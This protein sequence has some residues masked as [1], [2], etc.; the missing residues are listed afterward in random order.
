MKRTFTALALA[1]AISSVVHSA[2]DHSVVHSANDHSVAHLFN[3]YYP[4]EHSSAKDSSAKESCF[5]SGQ[6][7]ISYAA[8]SQ[9]PLRAGFFET[10][11]R[12]GFWHIDRGIDML[13]VTAGDKL[14]GVEIKFPANFKVKS[15]ENDSV[16]EISYNVTAAHHMP[17]FPSF[18]DF[19]KED[20]MSGKAMLCDSSYFVMFLTDQHLFATSGNSEPLYLPI[21]SGLVLQGWHEISSD[22]LP[23]VNLKILSATE[24]QQYEYEFL[25]NRLF[26]TLNPTYLDPGSIKEI[27]ETSAAYPIHE[28]ELCPPLDESEICAFN[29]T[30]INTRNDSDKKT[31][32]DEVQEALLSMA[33]GLNNYARQQVELSEQENQVIVDAV[34]NG[35]EGVGYILK[36]F[37]KA[38]TESIEGYRRLGAEILI[39]ALKDG[40]E[41]VGA[42]YTKAKAAENR[43][44]QQK[45]EA[46]YKNDQIIEDAVYNGMVSVGQAVKSGLEA[47]GA[48]LKATSSAVVGFM[49][50]SERNARIVV[51]DAVYNGV[52]SVGQAVKSGLEVAGAT[53]KATSSAVVGFMQQSERN[54]LI[55]VEDALYNGI[56]SVDQSIQSG[57]KT[58]GAK[59]KATSS[60][61]GDYA[62]R[63][64][65]RVSD[66]VA[67]S[68]EA[69]AAYAPPTV[70]SGASYYSAMASDA[71]VEYG[72]AAADGM[73]YVFGPKL[74]DD[75]AAWAAN[76]VSTHGN[77]FATR[78]VDGASYYGSKFAD[79]VSTHGNQ[80]ATR[81]VDGASHY[82]SKFADAVNDSVETFNDRMSYVFG[83]GLADD[84][85]AKAAEYSASTANW[86][87]TMLQPGAALN[88]N[89]SVEVPAVADYVEQSSEWLGSWGSYVSEVI[90]QAV[91]YLGVRR[92]EEPKE[93][94]TLFNLR[95]IR[96][97]SSAED[98]KPMSTLLPLYPSLKMHQSWMQ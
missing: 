77:Q 3:D 30:V 68:D 8:D 10:A 94:D 79:G 52:V 72:E 83:P 34:N 95:N 18:D 84:V 4:D 57:W 5:L 28:P 46:S 85:S 73:S 86:V 93:P 11:D 14:G 90:G 32:P 82:G 41:K 31:P 13:S 97:N 29:G 20:F 49:Q 64:G 67:Q 9:L 16:Q 89:S 75:V 78:V 42:L 22:G 12:L 59:L 58:T 24:E 65:D 62:S 45:S 81:V 70:Q 43:F 96:G 61:I 55:V 38:V 1:S 87:D 51:E 19:S 2:N 15:K 21:N 63:S 44:L 37:P 48:T 36:V 66:L 7:Y 71:V 80:F 54:D 88:N 92:E 53:L 17:I 60:V 50:Q 76:G 23:V 26:L 25:K 47:A 27:V 69:L 35:V 6:S 56:V 33:E 91:D 74:V 40:W 39:P 98:Y